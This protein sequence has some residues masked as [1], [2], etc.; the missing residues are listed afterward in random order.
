MH[1]QSMSVLSFF[2]LIDESVFFLSV[3]IVRV[4]L[5]GGLCMIYDE[6]CQF[7]AIWMPF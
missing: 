7:N 1:V 6:L 2:T 5:R 4:I 3:L